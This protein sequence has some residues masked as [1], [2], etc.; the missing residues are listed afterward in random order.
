MGTTKADCGKVPM[1]PT[2]TPNNRRSYLPVGRV[3]GGINEH[4]AA[5][6]Y[7]DGNPPAL[8]SSLAAHHVAD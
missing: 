2:S 3:L 6:V 8:S 7:V 1:D 5:R 4:S